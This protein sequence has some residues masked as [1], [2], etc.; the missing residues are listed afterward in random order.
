MHLCISFFILL[1]PVL[2]EYVRASKSNEQKQMK[3][4]RSA[5]VCRLFPLLDGSLLVVLPR[6]WCPTCC[7]TPLQKKKRARKIEE[8][9]L[10]GVW[11]IPW[12]TIEYS[13]YAVARGGILSVLNSV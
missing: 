7:P 5:V 11:R 6:G 1:A 8:T 12:I 13:S 3:L 9:K 2:S 4:R 10:R